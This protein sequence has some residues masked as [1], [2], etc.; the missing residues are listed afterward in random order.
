MTDEG[1]V[2][3]SCLLGFLNYWHEK[4][5][6][7]HW[8]NKVTSHCQLKPL[9]SFLNLGSRV[10]RCSPEIYLLNLMSK[11]RSASLDSFHINLVRTHEGDVKDFLKFVAT[12]IINIRNDLCYFGLISLK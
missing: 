5:C 3:Y 7:I 9:F 10:Q 2:Y 11:L 12:L 4:M 8:S 6:K 1:N